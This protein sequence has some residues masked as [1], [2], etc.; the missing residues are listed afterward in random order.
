MSQNPATR[1]RLGLAAGAV[2]VSTLA[3]SGCTTETV[4]QLPEEPTFVEASP[5][6][7][8]EP[9]VVEE[10][11]GAAAAI[12]CAGG[13]I[14]VPSGTTTGVE[15]TGECPTVTI[16]GNDLTVDMTG[17]VV[18]DVVVRADRVTVYASD[19]RSLSIDGYDTVVDLDR[20]A[21]VAVSGDRN[22]VRAAG[23]IDA[24]SVD[25]DDNILRAETGIGLIDDAGER[26][27]IG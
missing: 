1:R 5:S 2:L 23:G 4:V 19:V 7:T 6:S 22:T 26:N 18:D 15:V 16:R 10:Q 8:D 27:T 12:D 24:V 14:E 17:A 25:G 11:D 21:D 9:R 3:L 20:V 13:P